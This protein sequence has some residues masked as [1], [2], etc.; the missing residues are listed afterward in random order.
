MTN[1]YYINIIIFRFHFLQNIQFYL[2]EKFFIGKMFTAI[3]RLIIIKIMS[4]RRFSVFTNGYNSNSSLVIY[5]NKIILKYENLCPM[6]NDQKVHL[7]YPIVSFQNA[8]VLYLHSKVPLRQDNSQ[9][10]FW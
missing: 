5:M 7:F 2:L 6:D 1:Q 10:S 8:L 9:V 3:P 4:K